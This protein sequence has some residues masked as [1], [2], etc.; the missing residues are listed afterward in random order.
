M[1]VILIENN[2]IHIEEEG[3][4]ASF[5]NFDDCYKYTGF[6]L[7]SYSGKS[8]SY[9]P[10]RGLFVVFDGVNTY[11]K[12]LPDAM[13]ENMLSNIAL[14]KSRQADIFYKASLQQ[15]IQMKISQV[16]IYNN[17]MDVKPIA[18]SDGVLYKHTNA[19]A[20]TIRACELLGQA[21]TDPIYV[22]NGYWDNCDGTVATPFT[23][24]EL[25]AL[26]KFGYDVCADNYQTMK[27]HVAAIMAKQTVADVKAYSFTTGWR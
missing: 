21:D 15:A 26:F 16:L 13:F 20:E 5:P 3:Q 9:E 10:N 22:N 23:L 8:V 1:K 17:D 6:N 27:E 2:Q 18:Y 25:K 19:I 14:Y 4:V 11:T 24:G 12:P 7:S